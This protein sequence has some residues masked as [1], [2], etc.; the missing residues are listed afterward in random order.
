MFWELAR[1]AVPS[2]VLLKNSQ[3]SAQRITVAAI[4]ESLSWASTSEPMRSTPWLNGVSIRR[5][6]VPQIMPA[7][8]RRK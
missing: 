8:E 4:T 7:T 3:S 2:V 1:I 5:S 6:S